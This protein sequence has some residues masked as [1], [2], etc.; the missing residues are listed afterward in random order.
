MKTF[1]LLLIGCQIGTLALGASPVAAQMGRMGGGNPL[2]WFDKA[3]TNRDNRVTLSDFQRLQQ[4]L[5]ETRQALYDSRE[6]EAK[7][8]EQLSRAP[9]PTVT[10]RA[11]SPPPPRFLRLA[12]N[13]EILKFGFGATLIM[14]EIR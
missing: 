14:S 13:L 7:A 6:R 8:L 9:P 3:D 4:A 5:L 10:A 1:S 11:F 12:R 2:Q